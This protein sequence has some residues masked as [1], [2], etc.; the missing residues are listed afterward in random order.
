[1]T[2]LSIFQFFHFFFFSF[3]KFSHL[4]DFLFQLFVIRNSSPF[5]IIHL[6]CDEE[7]NSKIK[8]ASS[9]IELTAELIDEVISHRMDTRSKFLEGY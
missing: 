6:S 7:I 3:S 4:N 5:H 9:L 2:F 1:M 8:V